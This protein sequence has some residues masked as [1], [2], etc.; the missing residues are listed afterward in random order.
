MM[1]STWGTAQVRKMPGTSNRN[2]SITELRT[3]DGDLK[4]RTAMKLSISSPSPLKMDW[5]AQADDIEEHALITVGPLGE[6]AKGKTTRWKSTPWQNRGGPLQ[7][8]GMNCLTKQKQQTSKHKT[9]IKNQQQKNQTH[10]FETKW[11]FAEKNQNPKHQKVLFKLWD[12]SSHFFC[13]HRKRNQTIC[14]AYPT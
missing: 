3:P 9:N 10:K 1:K 8:I 14:S 12:F 11:N 13:P 2:N 5:S 6:I 7:N 4:T